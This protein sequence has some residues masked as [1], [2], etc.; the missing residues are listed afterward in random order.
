MSV[1]GVIEADAHGIDGEIAL[2]R[3]NGRGQLVKPRRG[4]AQEIEMAA[5][6]G[7]RGG[8]EM[9]VFDARL[10]FVSQLIEGSFNCMKVLNACYYARFKNYI[11]I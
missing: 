8:V 7:L 1:E 10:Y 4:V 6:E 5:A 9:Q 3:G 2:G 11:N